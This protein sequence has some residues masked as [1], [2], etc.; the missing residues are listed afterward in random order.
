MQ[1]CR[2]KAIAVALAAAALLATAAAAQTERVLYSFSQSNGSYPF[3]RLARDKSGALYGTTSRGGE[4]HAGTVFA[5]TQSGGAWKESVLHNFSGIDGVSPAEGVTEDPTG[6]LYGTTEKGGT[7]DRGAVFAL[8][9]SGGSWTEQ[10]LHNFSQ[11]QHDGYH[12]VSDLIIDRA[13]GALYGTTTQGGSR[14]CGT[15]FELSQSGG[16]WSE[17]RLYNFTG[18]NADGCYPLSDVHPDHTGALYG[19]TCLGGVGGNGTIYEL[20]QSAGIWTEATLY[21]FRVGNDG[22]CPNDLAVASTGTLYATTVYG[23]A[24]N[25][26]T[27]VE[28]TPS[29]GTWTENVILVFA[30]SDG[31]SPTGLLVDKSTGALYVTS[32]SGGANSSCGTVI[33][34]SQSHKNWNE[35]VLH[36]FGNGTDGCYPEARVIEDNKTGT[37]YGTTSGGGVHN[38]GTVYKLIP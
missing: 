5:L 27:V 29:H 32:A 28:L 15:V 12:P 31:E 1:N 10:V 8:T 38:Q 7:H 9:D 17:T 11:R 18:Y 14:G 33:K 24:R 4:S 22:Q 16:V 35:I 25:L 19:V 37:L 26:G 20:T 21:S 36:S 23:E 30:G 13:T 2:M 34:L 3:G 6:A